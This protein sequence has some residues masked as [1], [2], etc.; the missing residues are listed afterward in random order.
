M[1]WTGCEIEALNVWENNYKTISADDKTEGKIIFPNVRK[2]GVKGMDGRVAAPE[3]E[4]PN[5]VAGPF[6]VRMFGCLQT[7]VR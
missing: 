2:S 3:I 4:A 7:F 1:K 5:M 6:S